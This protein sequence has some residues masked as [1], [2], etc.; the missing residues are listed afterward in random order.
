MCMWKRNERKQ[1]TKMF[2]R[3]RVEYR[4]RNMDKTRHIKRGEKVMGKV[5]KS[6]AIGYIDWKNSKE[7]TNL[8]EAKKK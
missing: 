8:K 3:T 2:K 4:K 5:M 7:C 6:I 1:N